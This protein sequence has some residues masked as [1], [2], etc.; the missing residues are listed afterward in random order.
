M[1]VPRRRGLWARMHHSRSDSVR[2]VPGIGGSGTEHYCQSTGTG[3]P[4]PFGH[5]RHFGA[6]WDHGATFSEPRIFPRRPR[7]LVEADPTA[8]LHAPSWASIPTDETCEASKAFYARNRAPGQ[9]QSPPSMVGHAQKKV[10]ILQHTRRARL[11]LLTHTP[12]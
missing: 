5:F 7:S 12:F 10:H 1:S 6:G 3:L 4:V 2:R 9:S 8:F 11:A